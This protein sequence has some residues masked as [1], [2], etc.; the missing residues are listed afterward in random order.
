MTLD[1]IY[2]E[3]SQKEN[4]RTGKTWACNRPKIIN[5][6]AS[7]HLLPEIYRSFKFT[8]TKGQHY[9]QPLAKTKG[10]QRESGQGHGSA[11]ERFQY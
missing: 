11:G 8:D 2:A 9:K 7:L 6:L 5:S 10:Y 3:D 1:E 4:K